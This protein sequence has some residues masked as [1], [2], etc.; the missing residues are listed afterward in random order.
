MSHTF[1]D[2]TFLASDVIYREIALKETLTGVDSEISL[3]R[4][5]A[6]TFPDVRWD[7]QDVA[8]ETKDKLVIQWM[9]R[10]TVNGMMTEAEPV[11]VMHPRAGRILFNSD[12]RHRGA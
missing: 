3:M 7:I 8:A 1:D 2:Y 12:F 11:S 6:K 10:G 4:H 5:L 9:C